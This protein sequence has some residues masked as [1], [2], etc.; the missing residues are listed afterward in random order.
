MAR[1]AH[2]MPPVLPVLSAEDA[3]AWDAR[4]SEAG[5]HLGTLMDAAGRGAAHAVAARFGRE[6]GGGVLVAAGTG[7]NGGDGWV[8]ARALAAAG[9]SVWVASL[10]GQRSPLCDH[11]ARL[12]T[13]SGVRLL[14]PD[15]PWPSVALAVDAVLGTGA[16]GAP[17]GP[18]RALIDRLHDLRIPLVA[19][20]GPTGLDLATGVVHGNARAD[21]SI[22][23]GGPRRGHLLA[24]DESGT[25]VVLDIGLPPADT[26][27]PRLVTDAW[28][29]RQL[30]AFKA[31]DFKGTRGRVV[32]V[33]GA[34][35]MSGAVRMA[36]HAAFAAGAG[37]VHAIAPPE[38]VEELRLA[39]PEILTQP[40]RL[41]PEPGPDVLA[42]V[43]RADAVVLGPGLGRAE[44]R[45]PFILALA[46]AAH[47]VVI[48][49]DALTV[50]Q[51]QA[52]LLAKAVA[53]KRALITPHPGEFRTLVPDL[54]AEREVDPWAAAMDAAERLGLVVVL[55]GV[56]TVVAGPERSAWTVAAGNPGLGTGGSGDVLSGVA[57]TFLAQL[58][59]PLLVGA[60]AA[61]ALGDAGDIAARRHT[62]H[63]M[64]PADVIS[65]LPDVWRDWELR[66]GGAVA[67][68]PP[69][70][71]ELPAPASI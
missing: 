65:A 29:A 53:G 32:I 3:A 10:E 37:Y 48:D 11:A 13:A 39:E 70:L 41:G 63:A 31:N 59:E 33:G 50:F 52:D 67:I 8:V 14:A 45:V 1:P 47:R 61:Q 4:A 24:R 23:F 18:A 49:A 54:D 43:A 71:W 55:K 58:K 35:G 12:A 57:G 40:C 64:R 20:D 34:P 38:T 21:L 22:T 46:G 28:A 44:D 26:S 25:V 27:W 15:G 51:G 7:N 69:V 56:P 42:L 19:L 9:A 16:R 6:V 5:I 68:C 30:P 17:K 36:A 2:M 60:L 66:R 62:A